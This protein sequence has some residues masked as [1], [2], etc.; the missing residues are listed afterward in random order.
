MPTSRPT[1]V[2]HRGASKAAKE[3]TLEA[4]ALAGRMGA[5]MVELDVRRSA[6]GALVVHHDPFD[7]RPSYAPTL[8]EALDVC[9]AHA[10]EV[11]IEIKNSPRDPDFDPADTVAADVAA[12]LAVR[13]DGDRMLISSFNPATIAAVRQADPSLRTGYLFTRTLL[14]P[15]SAIADAGHCAIHPYDESVTSALV[16][17]AH[18][19]GLLVNV[20]TVDNPARMRE[21]TAL[22][23]D[24]IIT[25][26][27]DLALSTLVDVERASR[28]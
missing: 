2:A 9:I 6:D 17:E 22:G 23:V 15:L 26:V 14:L 12:L 24:A 16:D 25:N 10:M 7:E 13:G 21:L 4:F 3:N 5:A 20:W 27:P 1:V 18:T 19:L 11:N 28:R 8:A